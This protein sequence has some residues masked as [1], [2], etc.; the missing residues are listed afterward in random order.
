MLQSELSLFEFIEIH[1]MSGEVYDDDYSKDME[2]PFKAQTSNLVFSTISC[3]V[4]FDFNFAFKSFEPESEPKEFTKSASFS[5]NYH[6]SIWQPPQF[7]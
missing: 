2:L 1:Y 7:S 3:P 4:I 6:S 5:S